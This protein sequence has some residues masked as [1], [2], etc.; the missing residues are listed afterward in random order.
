MI[1]TVLSNILVNVIFI[2]LV[3]LKKTY[4]ALIQN[5]TFLKTFINKAKVDK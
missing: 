2:L 3:S 1:V 4:L 5:F